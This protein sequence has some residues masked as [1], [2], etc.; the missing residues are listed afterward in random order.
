MHSFIGDELGATYINTT[1]KKVVLLPFYNLLIR[2]VFMNFQ[3]SKSK[4]KE[5]SLIPMINVIFLLL[6]FFMVAGTVE[7]I[8]IFDVN[9]PQSENGEEKSASHAVVY[10][11]DDGRMAV[12]N[13]VVK[14]KDI[15]TIINTLFVDDP[16]QVVT[17]KSDANVP[18]DTLI[19]I[20]NLI[21]D[22]GGENILLVTQEKT[23]G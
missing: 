7:G 15:K 20:M 13:D 14:A 16:K 1:C 2:C 3:R 8:D 18:S 17:I 19:N 6:I 23:Q 5:V 12:N 9:L 4:S 10:L 22:A 21:E 11:K